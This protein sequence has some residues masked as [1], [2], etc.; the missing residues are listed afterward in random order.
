MC[1]SDL[2]TIISEEVGIN[3]PQPGIFQIALEKNGVGAEEA[4]MIGDSYS[5]DIQGA[6]N[7]GIDQIWLH[8]G[9]VDETATYIVSELSEV[10]KIL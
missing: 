8:Q 3:K 2:H 10:F 5:S 4:I 9:E 6:K 7:A 1:S